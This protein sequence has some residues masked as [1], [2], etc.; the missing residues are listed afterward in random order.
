MIIGGSIKTRVLFINAPEAL[1]K[2]IKTS[3][4]YIENDVLY[5]SKRS[6]TQ[7]PRIFYH[8]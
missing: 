6:I 8:I 1:V 5:I 7:V 3:N 4:I 2:D